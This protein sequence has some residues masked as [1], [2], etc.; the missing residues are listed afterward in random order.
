VRI[1]ERNLSRGAIYAESR[2]K[3]SSA[4]DWQDSVASQVL[5]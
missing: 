2:A 3:P 4:A 1:G 5:G